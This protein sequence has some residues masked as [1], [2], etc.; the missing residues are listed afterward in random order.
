MRHVRWRLD[1]RADTHIKG[2][3]V[4]IVAT[5]VSVSLGIGYYDVSLNNIYQDEQ[6]EALLSRSAD[7][8]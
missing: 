6:Q 3:S 2:Y 8:R 1:G 7:T 5:C 4:A